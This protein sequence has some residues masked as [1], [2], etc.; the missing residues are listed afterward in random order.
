LLNNTWVGNLTQFKERIMSKLQINS[1]ENESVFEISGIIGND[2]DLTSLAESPTSNLI[3]N[4]KEIMTITSVGVKK[5]V[6]GI[7]WLQEQGKTVEYHDCPEVFIE[8]C[9]MVPELCDNVKVH[10]FEVTFVCEECDEEEMQMLKV[11]EL[12]LANHT[13]TAPCPEC[14]EDMILENPNVFKFLTRK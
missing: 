13:P 3:L 9:N 5:W 11:E 10:T 2:T 12:D 8:Q 1:T 14:Q 7:K 6:E 4:F